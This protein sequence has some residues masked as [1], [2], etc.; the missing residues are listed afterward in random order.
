[1]IK[2]ELVQRIHQQNPHLYVRHVERL[3]EAI[4]DAIVCA[5]T[6][7]D[8]VEIRGFGVFS[9]KRRAPRPGRNPKTG[10][11]V[12]IAAKHHPLFKAGKNYVRASIDK[13]FLGYRIVTTDLL[14][15]TD[16]MKE[17]CLTIASDFNDVRFLFSFEKTD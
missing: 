7:G 12:A 17:V 5:L 15:A 3:V 13:A 14:E 8:R 9:R 1:V 2:S 10:A 11:P 16:E 6:D 4:L